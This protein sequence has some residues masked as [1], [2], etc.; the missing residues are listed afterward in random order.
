MTI[1]DGLGSLAAWLGGVLC[2]AQLCCQISKHVECRMWMMTSQLNFSLKLQYCLFIDWK[3]N[4]SL[5]IIFIIS[6]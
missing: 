3:Y 6:M 4:V 1:Y 5:I 2:C